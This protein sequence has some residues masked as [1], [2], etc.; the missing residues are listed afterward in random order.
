MNAR[1]DSVEDEDEDEDDDWLPLKLEVMVEF[2]E[3]LDVINPVDDDIRLEAVVFAPLVLVTEDEEGMLVV[4]FAELVLEMDVV[5]FGALLLR[6]GVVVASFGRVV[7]DALGVRN[8]ETPLRR[9]DTRDTGSSV[10]I[11]AMSGRETD[12]PNDKDSARSGEVEAA[13]DVDVSLVIATGGAEV[14]AMLAVEPP[15]VL[16]AAGVEAVADGRSVA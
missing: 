7:L 5:S 4:S 13:L 9:P 6:L 8:P 2:R 12:T 16:K 1:A 10:A 3:K 11:L 14:V 15:P